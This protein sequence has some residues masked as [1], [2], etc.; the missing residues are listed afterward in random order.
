MTRSV[1]FFFDVGSPTAY[2]ASTQLPAIC[3][4]AGAALVYRPML[5]GG[6]FQATGNV[7]PVSVPAKAKYWSIDMDR[8]AQR[9]GVPLARNPH[10][11]IVPTRSPSRPGL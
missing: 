3:A 1:E 11:P 9:Y 10:F 6:V 4:R 8:W 2:L 7:S 5:L